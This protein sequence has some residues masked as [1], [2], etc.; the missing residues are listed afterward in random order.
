[1][2][3]LP[4]KHIPTSRSLVGIGAQVLGQLQSPSTVSGLWERIRNNPEVGSFRNFVL[5]LNYLYAIGAL[6]YQNGFL[7]RSRP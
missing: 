5:A 2:T 6:D 3:L 7:S 1:M 4:T